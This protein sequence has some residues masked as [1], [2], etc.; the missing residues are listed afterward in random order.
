LVEVGLSLDDTPV[1]QSQVLDRIRV[2]SEHGIRVGLVATAAD[3]K[4]FADSIT[5]ILD[6]IGVERKIIRGGSTASVMARSV[7]AVRTLR[8]EHGGRNVYVRGI[9]GGIAH[10]LAFPIRGPGLIYDFRGDIVA[11]SEYR[12]SG[13]M[14]RTIIDRLLRLSLRRATGITCVSTGAAS[15]LA[16]KYNRHQVSVIPSCVDF[17]RIGFNP[18]IRT[19]IRSELGLQETDVVLA[20]AGGISR[21][22]QIPQM[23]RAWRALAKNPELKFLLLT[24]ETPTPDSDGPGEEQAP[25]GTI[26]LRGLS[27]ADVAEHLMAADIGFMLRESHPLN[28]VASPVKFAEYLSAGLAI[29][30]SPGV[31]DVSTLVADRSLGVLVD[32]DDESDIVNRTLE[33]VSSMRSEPESYR[34]R[35]NDVAKDTL[36][37]KAHLST[38]RDLLQIE[39]SAI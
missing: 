29:V 1:L 34:Q 33:L 17:E 38:W 18:E 6:A 24:N 39:E 28:F 12:G 31:G 13:K 27:R 8:R 20:Y 7:R 37:W 22:Q 16:S 35:S 9:W 4:R 3:E 32:L 26:I 5:P 11:E 2:Q 25:P 15:V 21:Y 10:A 36:D 23:L 14:S 30:T 19:A